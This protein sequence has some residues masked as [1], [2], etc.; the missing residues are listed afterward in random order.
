MEMGVDA[1]QPAVREGPLRKR[2]ER[3]RKVSEGNLL[4]DSNFAHKGKN[5]EL[6]EL[7]RFV[8]QIP[9]FTR[10]LRSLTN[11]IHLAEVVKRTSEEASFR[12]RWQMERTMLEGDKCFDQLDDLVAS[13]Y[14]P[15]RFFRLMC[16]QSLCMDGIQSS[17]YDSLRRDVVQTY[18]Y[19]YL[20][21][22]CN[23]EK[24]GLLKRRE[25][26]FGVMEKTSPYNKLREYLELINAEVD[27]VEP[28]DIS[29]VSSGYA[30]L[31]V[32]LVHYSVGGWS[33]SREDILRELPGRFYDVMQQHP[34]EDLETT[35]KRPVT[36]ATTYGSLASPPVTAWRQK[37]EA[38]ALG[39]VRGWSYLHGACGAPILVQE[40]E[41][42]LSY[43][44][45]H[46][47]DY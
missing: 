12:E 39:H 47:K 14:P 27:T 10:N 23:L 21:V 41:L 30:P 42:S 5:Q 24:A 36:T 9:I 31:T 43:H 32:R 11:H 45:L 29:Y 8:K 6:D 22:L 38:G 44:L 34:P 37:E 26:I 4:A 33:G 7:A 15:Y 25:G 46:D 17:R 3:R 28:N 16:L 18:G 40:T 13:Q 35:R 2:S 20:F 1:N 19:E